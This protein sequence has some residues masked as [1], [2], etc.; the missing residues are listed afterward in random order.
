MHLEKDPSLQKPQKLFFGLFGL[1]FLVAPFYYQ[2]N[3]GGEGLNLPYNSSIWIIACWIIAAAS[4][5]V[6]RT[7]TLILPKHWLGLAMLPIGAIFTG[8]IAENNNP[9]EWLVRCAVIIGGYL[10]FISF[11]QF[12]LN[13]RHLDRS[14]YI[15]L[16]MGIIAGI[17]GA[18]QTQPHFHLRDFLPYST[19]HQIVGIFQQVNLQAS[20]MATLLI[21]VYYLISRP[22]IKN[23]G[24]IVKVA[25]CIAALLASFSIAQTGSRVGLLGAVVGLLILLIG[26]WN[27]I[28]RS[29]PLLLSVVIIA[30]FA[31]AFIGSSGLLKTVNKFDRAIGGMNTDV[32]WQIYS[33]SWDT[34]LEKPLLGHGL[35]SFQKVF[36]ERRGALP[37]NEQTIALKSSPRYSHPHNELIFW[38][39][40]GGIVSII[41]ILAAAIYTLKQCWRVGK[42][43]GLGYISLLVPIILHTQVELP[44]YISNTHWLLLLFLLFFIHQQEKKVVRLHALSNS[45]QTL[46]PIVCISTALI[47]SIFLTHAQVANA[48]I[49]S[50]LKSRQT[51]TTYLK[52]ALNNY[53]YRDLAV[54]LLLVRDMRIAIKHN[55][56]KPITD[57]LHW[58]SS[59]IRIIPDVG[60]YLEMIIAYDALK[61]FTERDD[62]LEKAL[63]IYLNHPRLDKLKADLDKRSAITNTASVAT[64]NPSQANQP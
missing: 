57:F 29:Q 5:I 15:I 17:Y 9:T 7:S 39:I 45:A 52:T 8:L 61:Q 49:I 25:I 59:N 31:G 22:T 19:G 63:S 28:K 42:Q 64:P 51:Q 12:R 40:E 18:I 11:F 32:R 56:T 13:G 30:T 10:L 48:G 1:L 36:Q 44:F 24:W 27:T 62:T 54:R 55:E 34:F 14:L 60:L 47:G 33:L 6:H 53:Y 4:F 41:G 16:I 43:R 23:M 37:D 35:G 46:F 58:A 2:P 26:R 20:M 3:M 21:V 50:Y 38:M